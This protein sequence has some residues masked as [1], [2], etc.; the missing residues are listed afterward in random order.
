[1]IEMPSSFVEPADLSRPARRPPPGPGHPRRAPRF[2][3]T[4]AGLLAAAA[5]FLAAPPLAHAQK[6][7]KLLDLYATVVAGGMTGGGGGTAKSD[8]FHDSQG[9]ATGVNLGLRLLILD[10]S[11]RYLQTFDTGGGAQTLSTVMLGPSVEL[12]VVGGGV[13]LEGRPRPV[14]VVIRPG[15]AVGLG[16]GTASPVSPPLNNEQL[17]AKGLVVLGKFAVERLLGPFFGVGGEVQSGYHYMLS[18]SGTVN[19]PH[20][21]GWELALFATASAHF[22]I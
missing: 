8:F 22:G 7:V 15:M 16:F 10:F 20:T 17:S 5:S 2:M 14:K 18:G 11:V 3:G 1:M 13:D 21:Q 12:P 6:R 4:L 9:I 19:G